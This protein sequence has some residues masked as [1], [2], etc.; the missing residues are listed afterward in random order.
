MQAL[1]SVVQRSA[2]LFARFGGEKFAAILP[3]DGILVGVRYRQVVVALSLEHGYSAT[4]INVTISVGVAT[5]VSDFRKEPTTLLEE[6]FRMLYAAEDKGCK[7]CGWRWKNRKT[8]Q[9]WAIEQLF[10]NSENIAKILNGCLFYVLDPRHIVGARMNTLG[11]FI[12]FTVIYTVVMAAAGITLGMLGIEKSSGLNTPILIGISYWFFYS[13]SNKNS[14]TIEG[15]EKWKL[16]LFALFGDV[17][18]NIL[19]GTP[20]M[21][22]NEIPLKFLFVGMAII[23]PLHFLLLVIVNY[24]VRKQIIKQRPEL[25]QS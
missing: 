15:S 20:T 7:L 4:C 14:R 5:Q 24:G 12:R 25:A 8:R 23:I 1:D 16:I 10:Q 21:L 9:N 3:E 11:F 17:L 2:D 6:A 22:A 19:L 18:T 13:Y